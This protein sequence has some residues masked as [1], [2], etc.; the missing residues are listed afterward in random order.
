MYGIIGIL[1]FIV[2]LMITTWWVLGEHS[3]KGW[4][5]V[6]CI[7]ALFAG[8]FLILE[9]QATELTVKG[10]GTIKSAAEQAKVDVKAITDLKDRAEAHTA[11]VDRIAKEAAMA[12][13]LL[14]DL[15][16]NNQVAKNN[17]SRL[18]SSIA[19][20]NLA[21]RDLQLFTELNSTILSAKNDS[22]QAY[23]QLQIWG[24][25][26]SFRLQKE[27]AQAAKTIMNQHN[28][29]VI[30]TGFG[31]TWN[32]DVDPQVLSIDELWAAFSNTDPYK[33]IGILEFVWEERTDIPL[34]DRL[35]FLIDVLRSDDS[36]LVTEYAGRYFNEGTNDGFTP[37][38]SDSHL[39]WWEENKE[40]IE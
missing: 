4:A 6:I 7:V 29:N 28:L 32:E 22:R 16:I 30:I 14:N 35:Q 39:K 26:R 3:H 11:T 15:N 36:L 5:F 25:D 31:I 37:I 1:L 34:L 8:A 12:K 2:P 19:N 18:D 10:I 27:A 9:E 21:V 33:R 40:F 17:L 23:Q 24:E 13:Q 38:D 20:A